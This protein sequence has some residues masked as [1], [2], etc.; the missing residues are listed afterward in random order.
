[1][2]TENSIIFDS[3]PLASSNDCYLGHYCAEIVTLTL[4]HAVERSETPVH[5]PPGPYV[6]L[7]PFDLPLLTIRYVKHRQRIP[8]YEPEPRSLRGL[9]Q[10]ASLGCTWISRNVSWLQFSVFEKGRSIIGRVVSHGRESKCGRPWGTQVIHNAS[11]ICQ[12]T[13]PPHFLLSTG[14]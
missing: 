7:K 8:T 6:P 14:W 2:Q 12:H 1:M 13:C 9:G 5:L 3:V 10:H 4:Q 11:V